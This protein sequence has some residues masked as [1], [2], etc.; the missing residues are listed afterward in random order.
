MR[1]PASMPCRKCGLTA[2]PLGAFFFS[3]PPGSIGRGRAVASCH[4]TVFFYRLDLTTVDWG[5][6]RLGEGLGK[7]GS[8]PVLFE[9]QR[10][11]GETLQLPKERLQWVNG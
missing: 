4:R 10:C 9:R 3:N 7:E 6:R 11:S 2:G 5:H 8:G 1:D